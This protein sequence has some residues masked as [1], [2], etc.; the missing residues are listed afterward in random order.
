MIRWPWCG[1]AR[2]DEIVLDQTGPELGGHGVARARSQ[3]ATVPP[4]IGQSHSGLTRRDATGGL[5]RQLT[6]LP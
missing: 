3:R 2:T 1:E 6:C 5:P 4:F